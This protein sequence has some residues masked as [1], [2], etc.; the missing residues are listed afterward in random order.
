MAGHTALQGIFDLSLLPRGQLPTAPGAP[1]HFFLHLLL[2]LLTTCLA[3]SLLLLFISLGWRQSYYLDNMRHWQQSTPVLCACIYKLCCIFVIGCF[4]FLYWLSVSEVDHPV[5]DSDEEDYF[6]VSLLAI[7]EIATCIKNVHKV[8]DT[9]WSIMSYLDVNV[10][11]TLL[12]TRGQDT[13][14]S[15]NNWQWLS[16]C[17]QHYNEL[18]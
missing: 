13:H 6:G 2:L 7:W 4:R 10:C 15:E 14:F 16:V 18:F 8:L 5:A 1:P 17:I 12:T 11:V 9:L 3:T